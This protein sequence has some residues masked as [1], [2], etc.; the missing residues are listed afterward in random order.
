M[1]FVTKYLFFMAMGLFLV[2]AV[3]QAKRP[4]KLPAGAYIKSAKIEIVSGDIERYPTAIALLD[5][6][7]LHYGP[8]AEGLDLMR[9]VM[10]DYVEKASSPE[11]KMPH[12]EGMIAYYDSLKMCCESKDIKSKY[13]KGCKEF[14]RT[15]DS[16]NVDYWRRFYN[17]GIEQLNRIEE[18]AKSLLPDQYAA[19][20]YRGSQRPPDLCRAGYC[21]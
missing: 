18:T 6:L 13:K 3:A 2:G 1:K 9:K 12:V 21:L 15:A 5:S 16:T 7:F 20:H 4:R 14:L 10:V 19:G 17:D 11:A 8:H